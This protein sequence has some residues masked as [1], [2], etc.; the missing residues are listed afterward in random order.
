MDKSAL[1]SA[2]IRQLEADLDLQ[3]RAALTSRDEAIDEESKPENKYDTHAQEAAYLAQGQAKLVA[4]LHET[5]SHYRTMEMAT[6]NH[7]TPISVGAL[8]TLRAPDGTERHYFVGPKAGGLEVNHAGS[9]ILVVTPASPLG[10]QL[11]GRRRGDSVQIA[12]K[13]GAIPQQIAAVA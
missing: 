11:V 7:E 2:L 9:V 3:T 6:F 10:R 1:H 4:E 12:G 8:V 5:L 13:S